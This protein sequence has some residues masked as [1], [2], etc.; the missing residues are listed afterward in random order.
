MAKKAK[1]AVEES[2]EK[3]LWAADDKMR[4][5]IHWVVKCKRNVVIKVVDI[6]N[7]YYLE[8]IL[9]KVLMII[10]IDS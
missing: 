2:I 9:A 5:N 4:K 1:V 6:T 7:N 10:E 8:E 3:K